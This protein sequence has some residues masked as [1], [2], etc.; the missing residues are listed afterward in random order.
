MQEGVTSPCGCLEQ[1]LRWA[2]LSAVSSFWAL[3][4]P[5]QCFSMMLQGECLSHPHLN[6]LTL[7]SRVLQED[8]CKTANFPS[9]LSRNFS[10]LRVLRQSYKAGL[11]YSW[12]PA[13]ERW[14][15]VQK[16][17][18]SGSQYLSNLLCNLLSPGTARNANQRMHRIRTYILHNYY[19]RFM[20]CRVQNMT[21]A[22][23]LA[24]MV[25]QA[26]CMFL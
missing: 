26:T 13:P 5:F 11:Y 10:F 12:A 6:N 1:T 2:E 23:S 24:S 8:K 25:S 4:F 3:D 19:C 16:G 7:V 21:K 18:E 9:A 14:E 20:F 15:T 17:L 22:F